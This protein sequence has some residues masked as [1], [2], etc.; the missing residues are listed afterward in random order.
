MPNTRLIPARFTYHRPARL[1][2]ALELLARLPG[3]RVLAGGTDLL[4][5]IKTGE[6]R[7][8]AVVQ[9]LDIPELGAFTVSAG[10]AGGLLV[11]GAVPLYRLEEEKLLAASYTALHEAVRALASVQ[12]RTMA[13]LGGNLC[14]ASPSADTSGPLIVLGAEAQIAGLV[15]G[16]VALRRV[17]MA[18]FFTGPGATVLEPGELLVCLRLPEPPAASGSAFLKLGRV[19]L[20]MAKVSASAYVER[21]GN[22]LR[23]VRLAVGGAAPRPVRALEVEKAL[24]GAAFSLSAVQKAAALVQESIAPIDDVRSTAEYRRLMAPVVL[25]DAIS[26]AW[27]RAGGEAKP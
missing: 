3:A 14:N 8:E 20:D 26:A 24:S 17:Q 10:A 13:T 7:P 11:G 12:I 21:E 23:A 18:G 16:Q 19:T 9:V 27:H 2:E 25:R 1:E 6:C 22:R 5:Q 15:K 4:I